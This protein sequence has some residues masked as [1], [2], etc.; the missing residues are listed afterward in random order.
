[1]KDWRTRPG[2]ESWMLVNLAEALRATGRARRA[3]PVHQ[4]ALMLQESPRPHTIHRLWLA[5]DAALAGDAK[6]AESHLSGAR[7]DAVTPAYAAMRQLVEALLKAMQ[8]PPASFNEVRKII[9]QVTPKI[10]NFHSDRE[11]R[12]LYIKVTRALARRAPRW[13][14]RLWSLNKSF[15]S[16]RGS[17]TVAAARGLD[18]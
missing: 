7:M 5:A 2:V 6:C 4:H 18:S 8:T 12:I 3:R 14:D 10:V 15:I 1:M 17:Q 13:R 9:E 11:Q 16:M